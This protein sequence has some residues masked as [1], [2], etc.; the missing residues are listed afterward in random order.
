MTE[1]CFSVILCNFNEAK[2]S[3]LYLYAA[4]LTL[5]CHNQD[6]HPHL[7][8]LYQA[9]KINSLHLLSL[10]ASIYAVESFLMIEEKLCQYDRLIEIERIIAFGTYCQ[11]ALIK[12]INDIN[13]ERL[14]CLTLKTILD[15]RPQ[16]RKR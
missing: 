6:N 4:C 5:L 3:M 15:Y 14:E 10:L 1:E 11:I 8:L 13:D 7:S 9:I 16:S 2:V 12:N